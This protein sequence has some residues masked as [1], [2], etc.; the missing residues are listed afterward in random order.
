MSIRDRSGDE[1]RTEVFRHM[2][3][4]DKNFVQTLAKN[5][6]TLDIVYIV[7]L[8]F[9]SDICQDLYKS[10]P[11]KCLVNVRCPTVISCPAGILS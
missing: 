1:I 7:A 9:G 8:S 4:Q 2:S 11:K 10:T 5:D 3:A 6:L